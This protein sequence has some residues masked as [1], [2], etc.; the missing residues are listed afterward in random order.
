MG[1]WTAGALALQGRRFLLALLIPLHARMAIPLSHRRWLLQQERVFA[2]GVAQ[3]WP[4]ERFC[5]LRLR[6]WPLRPFVDLLNRP[7]GGQAYC[8][9]PLMP[10]GRV[11]PSLRHFRGER[12]IDN[13][14]PFPLPV[15]QAGWKQLRGRGFWCGPVCHHFGHQVADFGGRVLL[16]SLDPRPGALLWQRF[17]PGADQPLK[18]WQTS[19]LAY[20]NPG[21]KPIHWIDQPLQ[22][23]G[24]V[25]VPPQ[26]RLRAAPS[27]AHLA[28]VAFLQRRF[29]SAEAVPVLYVSR[30]RFSACKGRDSL[31]GGYAAENELE[32]VLQALGVRVI[33]PQELPLE[34]QLR[35]YRAAKVLIV[36]EGSAQHGLELLGYDGRKQ[37]LVICRRP[38]IPGMDLPL[39][40]RFPKVCFLQAVRA[41]WMAEGDV[42]W[43]ALA[44]L[45]F[46]AVA[47]ALG[48]LGLT[49]TEANVVALE[50]AADQQLAKLSAALPLMRL[51]LP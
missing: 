20:L 37:V 42:P 16:A 23:G 30:S 24:L 17:G 51:D 14:L 19:L 40:A 21:G 36:A 2:S 15:E 38:Q 18:A 7:S 33:H 29:A 5:C 28:A 1:E 27:L 49:L 9:G 47:R 25:V 44:L 12:C 48:A 10:A 31:L 13:P 6:R 41:L 32:I 45:D 39:R 26:A 4:G 50:Q 22:G 8:G 3:R 35:L 46:A 11:L 43:N 34:E